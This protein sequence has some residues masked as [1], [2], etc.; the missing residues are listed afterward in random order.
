MKTLDKITLSNGEQA[1]VVSGDINF[2]KYA[3]IV[4]LENH[5]VRVVDRENLTLAK[6]NPHENLGNHKK[7]N[8]FEIDQF[9]F[10]KNRCYY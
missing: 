4:E 3:L 5:D 1:T 2:Y 9:D 10:G 8:K 7:I 6:A